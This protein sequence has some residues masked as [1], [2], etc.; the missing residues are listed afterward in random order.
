MCSPEWPALRKYSLALLVGLIKFENSHKPTWFCAAGIAVAIAAVTVASM[1]CG[2]VVGARM[3]ATEDASQLA[4]STLQPTQLNVR[5]QID[6]Q[7]LVSP[8]QFLEVN[9]VVRKSHCVG[10]KPSLDMMSAPVCKILQVKTKEAHPFLLA[11]V[12]TALEKFP[13]CAKVLENVVRDGI[14]V[15]G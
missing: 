12:E 9:R 8:S 7:L 13:R 14:I 1:R 3:A 6:K 2:A 10:S 15:D 4:R 11:S 5:P